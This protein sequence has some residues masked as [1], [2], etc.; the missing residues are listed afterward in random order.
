MLKFNLRL[1]QQEFDFNF[2]L[3]S[4]PILGCSPGYFNENTVCLPCHIGTYSESD[5]AEYCIGCPSGFTTA[6]TGSSSIHDC[7]ITGDQLNF[8][9]RTKFNLLF[10]F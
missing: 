9:K 7:T 6:S 4:K 3:L 8:K 2:V 1:N 5:N 10:I